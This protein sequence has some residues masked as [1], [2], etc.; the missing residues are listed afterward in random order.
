[1]VSVY[2]LLSNSPCVVRIK[3]MS[4]VFLLESDCPL[5]VGA[6]VEKAET[7]SGSNYSVGEIRSIGLDMEGTDSLM[8]AV[9][10]EDT[11]GI[12][13][14]EDS[15]RVHWPEFSDEI[16]HSDSG[17]PTLLSFGPSVKACSSPL[18]LVPMLMLSNWY[19]SRSLLCCEPSY[20]EK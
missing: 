6:V 10:I 5:G 19:P 12:Q 14:T 17:V 16:A 2:Y 13:A 1:M 7:H 15:F 8:A 11:A 3:G 4:I 18:L 20:K 9:G